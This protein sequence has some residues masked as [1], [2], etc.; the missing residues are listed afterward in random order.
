MPLIVAALAG[1]GVLASTPLAGA[2]PTSSC[3]PHSSIGAS[4][5][6][7]AAC[8]VP[9]LDQ[10]RQ[11]TATT[12]GLPGD[13]YSYCG[14]TATMDGLA[15]FASHGAPALRP[16]AKDWAAA[17]NYDEMSSDIKDLGDL[18]GT[19]VSGGTTT[20]FFPGLDAWLRQ[21]QPGVPLLPNQLVTSYL[22][23]TDAGSE[24][25]ADLPTMAA[26]GAAGD[27]VIPN[28]AFMTYE[29]P[30]APATGPKQW[31]VVGGH[32]LAMSSATSPSTIGVRDP[33]NPIADHASQSPYAE[34]KY[35]LKPI[36]ST[37][38]YLD[39]SGNDVD[40]KATFLKVQSYF[41]DTSTTKNDLVGL[42]DHAR[43]ARARR[44]PGRVLRLGR[45]PRGPRPRRR[46]G[47]RS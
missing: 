43:G 31:L 9:D 12:T 42:A 36:T 26:E 27:I 46:S 33:A 14:P 11:V 13:G 5:F 24:L 47:S 8:G 34:E 19:T 30:P 16:G 1:L 37:F 23:V 45:A 22:W 21:T 41:L 4:S 25:P 3:T 10:I 15:Y 35:T 7:Y 18:M 20:G 6:D 39:S 32:Y 29:T 17:A 44:R 38:G 28:V 2:G 40:F